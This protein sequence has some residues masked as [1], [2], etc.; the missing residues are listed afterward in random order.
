VIGQ[1][2]RDVERFVGIDLAQLLRIVGQL[3]HVTSFP[4]L[5]SGDLC[6]QPK[7]MRYDVTRFLKISLAVSD[8]LGKNIVQGGTTE[9]RVTREGWFLCAV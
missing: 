7:R 8:I 5:H 2:R 4:F 1:L 6:V 9:C 3:S